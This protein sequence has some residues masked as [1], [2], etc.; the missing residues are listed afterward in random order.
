MKVGKYMSFFHRE[1]FYTNPSVVSCH[2]MVLQCIFCVQASTKLQHHLADHDE[3]CHVHLFFFL[4]EDLY[5]IPFV[6]SFHQMALKHLIVCMYAIHTKY[7]LC[8]S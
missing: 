7:E 6:V 3:S 5:A 1:S 2:Q 8:S 4:R